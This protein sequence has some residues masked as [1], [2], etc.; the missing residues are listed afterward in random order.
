MYKVFESTFEIIFSEKKIGNNFI[1]IFRSED[2]EDVYTSNYKT[3]LVVDPKPYEALIK[4]YQNHIFINAAGGIVKKDELFLW[5]FRNNNWDF[6]KG[7]IE[8]NESY[9]NAA[10]REVKEEC[11]LDDY[12]EVLNPLHKTF[13]VYSIGQKKYLKLTH[14]FL[15]NYT[16][17]AVLSPQ[18]EEGITKVVWVNYS[19]SC[20]HAKMSFKSIHDLWIRSKI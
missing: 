7:K 5:I 12:I 14:W 18:Y 8:N 3:F 13:H 6:P 10:I 17:N 11:G 9:K 2:I 20:E 15:M 19:E 1:Q 4:W 16:G